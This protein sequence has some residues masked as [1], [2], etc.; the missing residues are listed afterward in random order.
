MLDNRFRTYEVYGLTIS[1]EFEMRELRPCQNPS[2]I[3]VAV[4][5]ANL[6]L[7][8]PDATRK[9]TFSEN[10]QV[11]VL[12]PVAAFVILGTDTVLVEPKPGVS[13]DILAVPFL[14]PVL[15]ILLHLRGKFVLHGSAISF[16][17]KAY[18]FV[19]DKGAGKST[20]AAMLLKN[21]GV[22]LLTDDLLVVSDDLRV[23]CGYQQLKLSDEALGHSD[24]ENINVRPPPIADFPKHQVLLKKD[25]PID[26]V[27]IG[28]F[29]EL[30]R[31][32]QSQI[33][34][35]TV[36]E[37]ICILLR[38]SYISRFSKRAINKYEKQELFRIAATIAATNRVKR[39]CVPNGIGALDKVISTLETMP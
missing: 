20:L 23:L 14:G 33:E 13:V 21:P 7:M 37:A 27:S 1:S 6:G 3:D 9:F 24:Q 10:R 4:K 8:H 38:F 5:Y 25:G 12:P 36:V 34:D 29:F 15:A 39:I 31:G 17:G 30:E 2:T 11:I 18:G 28:G 22:Q 35:V 16:N 26:A 32:Q 19:G